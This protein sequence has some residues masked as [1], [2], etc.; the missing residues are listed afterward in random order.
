MILAEG[1]AGWIWEGRRG[2][3]VMEG[4]CSVEGGFPLVFVS[5]LFGEE[6]IVGRPAREAIICLFEMCV[7]GPEAWVEVGARGRPG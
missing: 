6:R 7:P 3:I 5:L 2:G 1:M 4:L